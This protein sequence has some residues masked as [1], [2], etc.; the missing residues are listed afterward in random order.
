MAPAAYNEMGIK[1][2][3]TGVIMTD[4]T[5]CEVIKK[6][7]DFYLRQLTEQNAARSAIGLAKIMIK[8]RRCL[9]CGSLFEST[10]NRLCGCQGHRHEGDHVLGHYATR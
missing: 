1:I 5:R 8:I 9:S 7:E 10:H 3:L 2:K 4:S 6:L